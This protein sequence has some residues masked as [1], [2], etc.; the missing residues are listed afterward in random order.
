MQKSA[1]LLWIW[2]ATA[3]MSFCPAL[4]TS[5]TTSVSQPIE[6]YRIADRYAPQIAGQYSALYTNLKTRVDAG[7]RNSHGSWEIKLTVSWVGVLNDDYFEV[8]GW[9]TVDTRGR[10]GFQMTGSNGNVVGNML[11]G[12]LAEE[13]AKEV[14]KPS[15][16]AQRPAAPKPL[17]DAEQNQAWDTNQQNATE[18][19][20]GTAYSKAFPTGVYGEGAQRYRP[21]LNKILVSAQDPL[22]GQVPFNIEDIGAV[23]TNIHLITR[24]YRRLVMEVDD[25]KIP[26]AYNFKIEFPS[27]NTWGGVQ[28]RRAGS[29]R[30]ALR[31]NSD[32]SWRPLAPNTGFYYWWL[33]PDGK[34]KVY[35]HLRN[36]TSP[37]AIQSHIL[38]YRFWSLPVTN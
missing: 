22:L 38:E 30:L 1:S 3:C 4:A 19:R 5:Y 29:G 23:D 2:M 14:N 11:I 35:I 25:R 26:Y 12:A 6:A 18:T 24:G 17:T 8:S 7:G 31:A 15:R 28:V 27:S 16:P 20:N 34:K 37:L 36:A 32:E 13:I 9:L 10:W 21:Q 33:T